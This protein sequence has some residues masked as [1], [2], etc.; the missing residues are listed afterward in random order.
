MQAMLTRPQAEDILFQEAYLL[1][2]LRL[3]EW[4][5]LFTDDGLYWMPIDPEADISVHASLMYD[6]PL[7]REE[8]VFHLLHNVFPAQSP[9]SRTQHLVSNVMVEPGAGGAALVRSAQVVYE[10]RTGDYTQV[11]LGDIRPLIAQVEHTLRQEGGAWKIACK[12]ILLLNRDAWQGNLTF[13]I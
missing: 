6:T 1:D 4:N 9:R 5:A 10:M 13:Y 3:D 11:G 8:R 7:R 12:K 2:R